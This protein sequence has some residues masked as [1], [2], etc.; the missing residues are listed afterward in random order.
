[1]QEVIRKPFKLK[2][3]RGI[4]QPQ[5]G[6]IGGALGNLG[7]T[8]DL[9]AAT[10]SY[11]EFTLGTWVPGSTSDKQISFQITGKNAASS[12]MTQAIDIIKLIP[13]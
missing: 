8:I 2:N 11:T 6:K 4:V 7:G 12:G 1:M 5:I 9:Y 3:N 13:Q 10:E